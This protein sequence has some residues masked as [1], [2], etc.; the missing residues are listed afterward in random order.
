M[1]D[2]VPMI[3]VGEIS[4]HFRGIMFCF[5]LR[6]GGF[7]SHLFIIVSI[8]IITS[9]DDMMSISELSL[10]IAI[11]YG[12][13]IKGATQRET[14]RCRFGDRIFLF[15]LRLVELNWGHFGSS[16]STQNGEKYPT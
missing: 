4:G 14:G 6:R 16:D 3:S 5:L 11:G 10:I 8:P 1:H 13:S 7:S 9:H 2:A 15:G 12:L